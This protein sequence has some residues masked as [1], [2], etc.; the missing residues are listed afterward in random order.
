[1][2]GERR[3]T[4]RRRRARSHGQVRQDA[5]GRARRSRQA[6]RRRRAEDVA[7]SPASGPARVESVRDSAASTRRRRGASVG[8]SAL[9]SVASKADTT[10]GRA[11]ITAFRTVDWLPELS[12]SIQFENTRVS[13]RDANAQ[14]VLE[15]AATRVTG[16]Q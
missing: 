16:I 7:D 3:V 1:M 14:I 10:L 12:F 8:R 2:L 13:R 9:F 11:V 6:P 15:G 4:S 5:R